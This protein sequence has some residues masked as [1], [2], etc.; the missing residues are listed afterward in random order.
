[1]IEHEKKIFCNRTL[2]LYSVQAIGY[3]MDYTLIHYN[4]EEWEYRAFENV[5]QKMLSEG[6]PVENIKF[7][8]SKFTRGLVID[9]ELGNIIKADK[10]G[11]V[12]KALHGSK[13]LDFKEM[14]RLYSRT[15]V[16]LSSSRYSFLN[17]LFSLSEACLYSELI[18]LL[19]QGKLP[20]IMGYS[21]LYK[22]VQKNLDIA[23]ME[24]ALKE[25]IVAHPENFVDLDPE[26]PITLL[27]QKE[28]G[29][30]LMLITNSEWPYTKAMMSY[31][32]DRYLPNGM[33]WQELF[34]VVVCMARK[35]DFFS[36]NSPFFEVINDEGALMPI[37]GSFK[38]KKV[39]VGGNALK[40]EEFLGI[41]GDDILY[42]GDH[43]FSDVNISKSILR[44]RTA[45]ILRELEEELKFIKQ[46][47]ESHAKLQQLM[48]LKEDLEMEF[49]NL[50]LQ[51]L[52]KNK[53]YGM[54][55]DLTQEEIKSKIHELKDKISELDSE[56]GPLAVQDGVDF[57]NN[58]G[59]LLRSGN[60]KSHL[61]RQ[62]EKY[63][64]IYTSRVSN[65]MAYTPFMFFRSY[66]GT[67]PHDYL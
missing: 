50:R 10:F 20:K 66:R 34:H 60:D 58:W 43:I 26:I 2:N 9:R 48:K 42:V 28:C 6:F 62:I 38:E 54:K 29:K 55:I 30:K 33:K 13:Q 63:A 45:L 32:F 4:V 59:Y 40:I 14:R 7:D 15:T 22:K 53:K 56:I 17:T 52:Q 11:Y 47:S 65:F 24:G 18:D 3:D 23:H 8:Y 51:L 12:K 67:L 39:Y 49:F 35:P 27:D 16:D 5:K 37:N 57:N 64:D 25:E 46:N 21:D 41:S 61:A 19:D 31:A 36:H 44:W 1:M